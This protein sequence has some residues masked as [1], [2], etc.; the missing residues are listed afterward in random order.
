MGHVGIPEFLEQKW[1]RHAE[2][3]ARR[4]PNP[5]PQIAQKLSFGGSWDTVDRSGRRVPGSHLSWWRTDCVAGHVRFELRN[6]VANYAF[7]KSRRFAGNQPNSGHGDHSRLSCGTGDTQLGPGGQHPAPSRTR[8]SKDDPPAAKPAT[9]LLSLRW[10]FR[11]K[12]ACVV[13]TDVEPDRLAPLT[14]PPPIGLRGV[15]VVAARCCADA[16][17]RSFACPSAKLRA[18][19]RRGLHPRTVRRRP[20]AVSPWGER[21]RSRHGCWHCYADRAAPP[22][23]PSRAPPAGNRTRCAP[24]WPP[25][26]ARSSG[27]GWSRRRRTAS[28]CIGLSAARL[29]PMPRVCRVRSHAGALD[30]PGRDR[31]RDCSFALACA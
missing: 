1:T 23:P 3:G 28:A 5:V 7:E 4:T 2:G 13:I 15:W 12:R 14:P 17:E 8:W 20:A 22:S 11:A 29:P 16:L 24:S 25:W 30:K 26:C 21:I 18:P 19:S 9:P 27:S 10:T 31:G 6:V